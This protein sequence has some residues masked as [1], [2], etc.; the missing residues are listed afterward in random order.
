MISFEL[1]PTQRTYV[2]IVPRPPLHPAENRGYRELYAACRHLIERWLRLAAAIDDTEAAGVLEEVAV[3]VRELLEELEA[4]T[5]I[6]E[7]HGRPAAQGVGARLGDARSLVVDKA[8]DTGPALRLAVLDIEH[9][10]TLLAH[11]AALAKARA[12]LQLEEFCESWAKRL[13]PQVKAVRQAGI[14]LGNDP[15]RAAR[16][17]DESP[18]GRAINRAGWVIGTVG[19]WFDRRVAGIRGDDEDEE[20]PKR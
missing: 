10:V 13:R 3:D 7:L 17:L 16:P 9:I 6:Y 15:D 14:E 19:E 4:E 1:F 20:G 2:R 11:L 18:T 12:D 5:A 8:L